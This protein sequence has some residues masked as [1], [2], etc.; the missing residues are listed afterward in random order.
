MVVVLLVLLLLPHQLH[1]QMLYAAAHSPVGSEVEHESDRK[2]LAQL[3]P[4]IP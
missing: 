4:G 1:Q 2:H 3:S